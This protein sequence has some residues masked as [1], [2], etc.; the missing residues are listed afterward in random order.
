MTTT[1][2][3]IRERRRALGISRLSLAVRAGVSVSW[4]QQ[5]EGGVQPHGQTLRRVLDTLDEL[6]GAD[7]EAW[8]PDEAA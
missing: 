8:Q 5:L 2:L 6:E 4:L 3:G 1:T 7:R